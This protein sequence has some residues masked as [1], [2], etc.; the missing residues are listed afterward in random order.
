ME[1]RT[2]SRYKQL[3]TGIIIGFIMAFATTTFAAV[4]LKI[5]PNPYPILVNGVEQ[6]IEGYNINGSTYLKLAGV[7]KATGSQ[8]KFNGEAKQIEITTIPTPASEQNIKKENDGMAAEIIDSKIWVSLREAGINNGLLVGNKGDG[9]TYIEKG[10]L[11]ISYVNPNFSSDD[12]VIVVDTEK[13]ALSLI[14]Y[15]G[16]TYAKISDLKNMGFIN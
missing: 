8:V 10:E 13:G 14:R 11:K 15:N 5:L 2:M 4:E 12:E 7:G 3:I 6:A 16:E 9:K 1:V